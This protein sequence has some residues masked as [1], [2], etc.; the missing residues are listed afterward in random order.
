MQE[1]TQEQKLL[2]QVTQLKA[3]LFD[4]EDVL[5]N[6]QEQAQNIIGLVVDSLDL[7]VE[8]LE[9]FVKAVQALKKEVPAEV[10]A[11]SLPKAD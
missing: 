10:E 5:R 7:Q 1:Q 6:T 9:D 4:T 3:R 8:S 11:E 2:E